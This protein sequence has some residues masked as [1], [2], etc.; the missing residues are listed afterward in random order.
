MWF[1]RRS[2]GCKVIAAAA[3]IVA[4]AVGTAPASEPA[5][6]FRDPLDVASKP[7]AMSASAPL[8]AVAVAGQRSIAAGQRGHIVYSDDQGRHWKQAAVPVSVDLTALSFANARQGWAVGHDGVVL[9]TQDGGATWSKQLDGRGLGQAMAAF[10]QQPPSGT[11]PQALQ[12]IQAE[13]RRMGTE[14]PQRPFLSVAFTSATHGY[15][16]GAFGLIMRTE[17]GGQHWLPALEQV[18]NPGF[19][20]FYSIRNHGGALL[21]AGEQGFVARLDSRSGRFERLP[22]PYKGTFF[23]TV[24]GKGFLM[25]YGLRG[26]AYRSVDDGLTWTRS[27]TGSLAGITAGAS[28]DAG[29]TVLLATQ[30]GE[31]LA[32]HDQGATFQR[33]KPVGGDVPYF[34]IWPLPGRSLAIAGLTGASVRSY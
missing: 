29:A 24:Q 31:L 21:L 30:A 1:E 23:G 6:G 13:A 22:V 4:M 16:V 5:G 14:G 18:D 12:A 33:L 15:A 32:T 3:A 25:A 26:N 2:T 28:V 8:M 10:Y 19:L 9:A 7:S 27:Q 17:D 20:H 34:D 11:T